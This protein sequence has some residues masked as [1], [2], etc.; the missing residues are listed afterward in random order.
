MSLEEIASRA[1]RARQYIRDN[2]GRFK[3]QFGKAWH[4][5]ILDRVRSMFGV[6]AQRHPHGEEVDGIKRKRAPLAE[7]TV[8][9]SGPVGSGK[10]ALLSVIDAGLKTIGVEAQFDDE[11]EGREVRGSMGDPVES[12]RH[13]VP[14]IVSGPVILRVA[15][16]RPE[17]VSETT[18]VEDVCTKAQWK[19][20]RSLTSKE[21]ESLNKGD[22]ERTKAAKGCGKAYVEGKGFCVYTHRARS[23]FYERP[24]LI[25]TSALK[26]IQSTG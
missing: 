8:T 4:Q 9:V 6:E 16:E 12:A 18:L 10:T 17:S 26:F 19:N 22:S 5:H 3:Q 1:E 7:I 23:K 2:K 13:A 14:G 15:Y 25:P 11:G 24:D 21:V 20:R